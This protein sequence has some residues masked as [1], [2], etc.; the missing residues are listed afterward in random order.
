MNPKPPTY[1]ARPIDGGPFTA[2]PAK[3]EEWRAEPKYNGWRSLVHIPSGAMFNR[4]L[5]PLST[6]RNRCLLR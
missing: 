6:D 1:P 2:A 4:Q 5:E 3:I